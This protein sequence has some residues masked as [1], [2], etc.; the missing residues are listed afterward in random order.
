[1]R[2][3]LRRLIGQNTRESGSALKMLVSHLQVVPPGHD[4]AVADPRADHL[5]REL[6]SQLGLERAAQIL[7]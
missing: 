7:E 4:F 3:F 6:L 5:D 1:V 2:R